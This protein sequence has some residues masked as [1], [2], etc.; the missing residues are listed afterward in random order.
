MAGNQWRLDTVLRP[1]VPVINVQ[2][3]AADRRHLHFHQNIV[4][5]NL[6]MGILPD[7]RSGAASGF[8]TASMV[9]GINS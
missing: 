3:G 8:T 5:A 2:I 6:R 7:I 9:S 1:L 4:R